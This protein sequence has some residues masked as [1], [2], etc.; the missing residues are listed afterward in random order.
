MELLQELSQ[1]VQCMGDSMAGTVGAVQM[2]QCVWV[3]VWMQCVCVFAAEPAVFGVCAD[4]SRLSPPDKYQCLC[5]SCQASGPLCPWEQP[6][7]QFGGV[8]LQQSKPL[9]HLGDHSATEP[10]S[11]NF[12][13]CAECRERYCVSQ[14][15]GID[16][17]KPKRCVNIT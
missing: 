1:V 5:A 17:F 10:S 11:V 12:L 16:L 4:R 6:A 3:L 7:G 8:Q 2:S 15:T 14:A 9:F 13:D